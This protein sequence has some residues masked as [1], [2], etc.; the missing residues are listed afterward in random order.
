M[1][2]SLDE[3]Y[4]EYFQ[5]FSHYPSLNQF[6]LF[7]NVKY[8]EAQN[9]ILSRHPNRNRKLSANLSTQTKTRLPSKPRAYTSITKPIT[10]H[11][12]ASDDTSSH[13]T[14]PLPR[15]V[16]T[17]NHRSSTL[18]DTN[19]TQKV[20]K[21][22]ESSPSL[23]LHSP[24][25]RRIPCHKLRKSLS[26]D[27]KDPKTHN[28]PKQ[29]SAPSC[30]TRNTANSVN[31]SATKSDK[32]GYI[33]FNENYCHKHVLS[34]EPANPNGQDL[35]KYSGIDADDHN[36]YYHEMDQQNELKSNT[37]NPYLD[38][39]VLQSLTIHTFKL[40][41]AIDL[42][43]DGC[44]ISYCLPNGKVYVHSNWRGEK[45]NKVDINAKIKS[46]VLLDQYGKRLAFGF[47]ASYIYSN[48]NNDND[49]QWMLFERFKMNLKQHITATNG[50]AFESQRVFVSVFQFMKEQVWYYLKKLKLHH[51]VKSIQD[52]QWIITV[53]AIMDD[54]AKNKMREWAFEAGLADEMIPN[55]IK[56][57]YE[58]DCASLSIQHKIM[59]IQN[60]KDTTHQP[61]L[62]VNDTR[63]IRDVMHLF[64]KGSRYILID[65]GGGTIDVSCHESMDDMKIKEVAC[66]S[67][68]NWG[69][70][71]IDDEFM[72]LLDNIFTAE[73]MKQFAAKD[74]HSYY[75]LLNNFRASKHSFYHQSNSSKA[76]H[77][78]DLTYAFV[79]FLED[80]CERYNTQLEEII[81]KSIYASQI[82]LIGEYLELSFNIWSKILFGVVMGPI[83]KHVSRLLDRDEMK[84]CKYM[85]LVGGLSESKYFQYR[86]KQTF[87][88]N[89]E[90]IIPQRPILSVVEGAALFGVFNTFVQARVLSKCYGTCVNSRHLNKS[91]MN[92]KMVVELSDEEKQK[93][94]N[95]KR[96][97]FS[98]IFKPIV[99]KDQIV[100][101]DGKP[102][103]IEGARNTSNKAQKHTTVKIFQCDAYNDASNTFFINTDS[104]NNGNMKLMGTACIVWPKD[105][106]QRNKI[107]LELYFHDTTI[108]GYVYAEKYPDDK[109]VLQIRYEFQ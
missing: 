2:T 80:Q 62:L 48:I 46:R 47:A 61:L 70:C 33:Y 103:I 96:Q 95:H 27:Y 69:S 108:R 51:T 66:P 84:E 68:G 56:I 31:V 55:H 82:S 4:A 75:Q 77:C 13:P 14:P 81:S 49:Q 74:S 89:V 42:G 72:K 38:H 87:G 26:L 39:S 11:S 20:N 98:K 104:V 93:H 50:T 64:Q 92:Q 21:A 16:S 30:V 88:S 43:T 65:A 32:D 109:K 67:G 91:W 23:L 34:N 76:S 78:V 54:V 18:D 40:F 22:T 36:G 45:L 107:V 3:K 58:P 53:P 79:S 28:T 59:E 105:D 7:A 63:S 57:V 37:Q 97:C 8:V 71:I 99:H 94:Y 85:C 86:M 83:I 24:D 19:H 35:R 44:S 12:D 25:K 52:I 41:C 1:S 101:I 29:P 6:R 73:W 17:E 106:K 60:S 15:S 5:R 9:Y 100:S 10:K 90:L 102:M